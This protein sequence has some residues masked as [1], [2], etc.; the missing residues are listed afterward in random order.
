MNFASASL[1]S[2]AVGHQA[3][4]ISVLLVTVFTPRILQVVD[5]CVSTYLICTSCL[6]KDEGRDQM[7]L[8]INC[9]NWNRCL[10]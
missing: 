1:V 2:D 5:N 6:L 10:L 8:K 3:E 9:L 4:C 7:T